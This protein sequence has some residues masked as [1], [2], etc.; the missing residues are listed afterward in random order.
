[1]RSDRYNDA[2]FNAPLDLLSHTS[3]LSNN[4]IIE[5]ASLYLFPFSTMNPASGG[6]VSRPGIS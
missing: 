3:L 6:T 4:S 2:L 5:E 1:M